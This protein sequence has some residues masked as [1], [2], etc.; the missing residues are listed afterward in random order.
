MIIRNAADLGLVLTEVVQ[1]TPQPVFSRKL[2]PTTAILNG[3]VLDYYR[4]FIF[5]VNSPLF[6]H[7]YRHLHYEILR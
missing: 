5:L 6:R 2:K 7:W 3:M 1:I 4:Y